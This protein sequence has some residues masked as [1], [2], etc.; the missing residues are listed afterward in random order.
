MREVAKAVDLCGSL[1]EERVDPIVAVKFVEAE[2]LV[3]QLAAMR[4]QRRVKGREPQ[5][6]V[7]ALA[8]LDEPGGVA[9]PL[10]CQ[11]VQGAELVVGTEDAPRCAPN[12]ARPVLELR[13]AGKGHGRQVARGGQL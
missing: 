9:H 6:E 11:V 1:R 10:G 12:P 2:D 5:V 4:D 13:V 8:E 3:V 7:D